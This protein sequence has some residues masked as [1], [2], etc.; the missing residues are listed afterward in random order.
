MG[1]REREIERE[2]ERA[3]VSRR[4]RGKETGRRSEKGFMGSG[5]F[6]GSFRFGVSTMTPGR[7]HSSRAQWPVPGP[8]RAPIAQPKRGYPVVKTV[9][10]HRPGPAR[11][12]PAT[13]ARW[14][15]PHRAPVPGRAASTRW[16][17]GA[18]AGARPGPGYL[19]KLT[20]S[21]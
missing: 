2:G 6:C 12:P 17:A 19:Q 8:G 13:G 15:W 4:R 3:R 20:F 21:T 5:S 10:G 9:T 18:R 16:A 1:E 14:L 7:L 11:H